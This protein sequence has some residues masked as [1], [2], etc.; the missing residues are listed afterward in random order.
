ML[1]ISGCISCEKCTVRTKRGSKTKSQLQSSRMMDAVHVMHTRMEDCLRRPDAMHNVELFY[2][3][4]EEIYSVQGATL[5]KL[6][7]IVY[8]WI[9]DRLWCSGCGWWRECKCTLFTDHIS[10]K[11]SEKPNFSTHRVQSGR[12][13]LAWNDSGKC[14]LWNLAI[15]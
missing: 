4:K 12:W 5:L 13:G 6:R 2:L 7:T 3:E 9:C 14:V 1:G 10:N 11:Y 8:S 15:I